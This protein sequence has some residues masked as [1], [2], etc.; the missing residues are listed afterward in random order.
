MPE[1]SPPIPAFARSFESEALRRIANV[2]YDAI[3][4]KLNCDTST[5]SRML[6]DRGLK[7]AEVALL[8]D[9]LGWKVVNR[10]QVCV[11]RDVFDAYKTIA[12][13]ALLSPGQ[14]NWEDD[15]A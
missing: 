6:G 8:L 14:L 12:R 5:V 4:T 7:L 3:A 15:A 2:K 1:A 9:A 10:G 13:T 11:P